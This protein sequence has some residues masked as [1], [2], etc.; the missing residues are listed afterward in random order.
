MKMT[1][2]VLGLLFLIVGILFS[3]GRLLKYVHAWQEMSEEEKSRIHIERLYRNVGLMI[4]SSG[5]IFFLNG[6]SK[7]FS[8]HGFIVAMIIWLGIAVFDVIY[9]EKSSRYQIK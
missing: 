9:I 7:N 2:V 5:C 3:T 4:A 8:D 1:C 6:I